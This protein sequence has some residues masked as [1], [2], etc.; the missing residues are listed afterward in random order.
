M[1][2]DEGIYFKKIFIES[3]SDLPKEG[4]YP[5]HPKNSSDWYVI[6]MWCDL[7]KKTTSQWIEEYDWYLMPLPVNEVKT[8][9]EI[10]TAILFIIENSSKDDFVMKNCQITNHDGDDNSIELA[11]YWREQKTIVDNHLTNLNT[12]ASQFQGKDNRDL[13]IDKQKEV[14]DALGAY[15]THVVIMWNKDLEDDESKDLKLRLWE[16]VKQLRSELSSLQSATMHDLNNA[17]QAE[18]EKVVYP[19]LDKFAELEKIQSGEVKEETTLKDELINCELSLHP[20][21]SA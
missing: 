5:V 7:N 2:T 4:Y 14:I 12:F 6:S 10:E 16:N 21:E 15:S 13:I 3:E 11:G 17:D 20:E 19:D 1:K 8:A 9:E 18:E